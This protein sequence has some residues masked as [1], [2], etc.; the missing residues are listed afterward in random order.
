MNKTV[1]AG[2]MAQ[3]VELLTY[4]AQ[5]PEFKPK[6]LRKENMIQLNSRICGLLKENEVSLLLLTL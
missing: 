4:Q 5:S 6:V 2:G 1:R 3:V